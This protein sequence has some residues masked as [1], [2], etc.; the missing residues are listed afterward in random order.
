MVFSTITYNHRDVQQLCLWLHLLH[1]RNHM[2]WMLVVIHW[3]YH[4]DL[5]LSL[6]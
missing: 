3:V 5:H 6:A 2:S 1:L 4:L